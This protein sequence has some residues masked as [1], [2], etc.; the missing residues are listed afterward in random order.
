MRGKIHSRR[1]VV[2][3]YAISL[4]RMVTNSPPDEPGSRLSHALGGGAINEAIRRGTTTPSTAVGFDP[5]HHPS[6]LWHSLEGLHRY[7]NYLS[8]WTSESSTSA[9]DRLEASLVAQLEKVREQ[10]RAQR[11]RRTEM[12]TIVQRV[13]Q[14]SPER[15]ERLLRV[16]TSWNEVMDT[17]LDPSAANTIRASKQFAA[18]PPCL[19][20]ILDGTASLQLDVGPLTAWMDEV[21]PDVFGFPLLS[22]GFCKELCEYMKAIGGALATTTPPLQRTSVVRNLDLIGLAWLNDL[23]FAL[24]LKPLTKHLFASSEAAGELDWRNGYVASYAATPSPATP[25]E[26]L[27]MHTDDSEVTMNVCLGE[28]GFGGGDVEFYG[29]RGE[30]PQPASPDVY[31]PV[32]GRA[33]LHAGRHFHSVTTV[34]GDRNRYAWILWARSW[35]GVRSHTCPCCWLNRRHDENCISGPQWN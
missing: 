21:V 23:M 19:Q 2:S 25:R 33:I 27:V 34:T 28:D 14:S 35:Q 3:F 16:P 24:V 12:A 6:H 15:W 5:C 17:I 13:M 1:G 29:L 31:E 18:N 4:R 22:K 26:R 20:D 8:R 32:V 7:P 30:S 11:E 9:M 10:R